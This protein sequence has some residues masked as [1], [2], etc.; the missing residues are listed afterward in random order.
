VETNEGEVYFSLVGDNFDPDEITKYVGLSPTKVRKKNTPKPKIN[1]WELS[2]GKITNDYI[3]IYEMASF[4]IE[5][6]EP[7]KEL[8]I[9]ALKKFNAKAHLE[10]VLWFTSNEN[11]SMPAIGFEQ[12]II[13]FLSDVN[14]YIDIDTY[15]S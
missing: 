11:I 15:K 13:K 7:K 1:S 10:V 4:L 12:K 9:G 3:D 8:I 2:I 14:A 6:L 5:I